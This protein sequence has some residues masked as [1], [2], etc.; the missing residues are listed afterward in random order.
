MT[1]NDLD[2]SGF[3]E[4]LLIESATDDID[5]RWALQVVWRLGIAT[6][7][8]VAGA[9]TRLASAVDALLR[10]GLVKAGFPTKAPTGDVL[11]REMDGSVEQIV[12]TIRS[13]SAVPN[14]WDVLWFTA[15]ETGRVAAGRLLGERLRAALAGLDALRYI[16]AGLLGPALENSRSEIASRLARLGLAPRVD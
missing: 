12:E 8:D 1:G 14:S 16:D 3:A 9:A 4:E 11:F 13:V 10:R 5:L 7:A 2:L 6:E 15:T